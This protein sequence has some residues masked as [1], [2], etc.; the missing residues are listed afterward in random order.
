MVLAQNLDSKR[1]PR[2]VYPIKWHERKRRPFWG[3]YR[4]E[5]EKCFYTK[6]CM[7][8]RKKNVDFYCPR[9][10]HSTI[11]VLLVPL[12]FIAHYL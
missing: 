8:K 4:V 9:Q 3:Q 6:N 5:T 2:L 11:A 10:L 12:I 1:V 7:F